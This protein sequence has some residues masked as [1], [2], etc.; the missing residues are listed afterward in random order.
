MSDEDL[1]CER[2]GEPADFEL[3][4]HMTPVS[5]K[6]KTAMEQNGPFDKASAICLDCI[7]EVGVAL[8]EDMEGYTQ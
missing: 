5:L 6:G 8:G 7:N 3:L 1:K 2:C 4:T